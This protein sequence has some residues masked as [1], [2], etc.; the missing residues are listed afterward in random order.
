MM[1]VIRTVT[2]RPS[3]A[4]TRCQQRAFQCRKVFPFRLLLM[5]SLWWQI[6]WCWCQHQQWWSLYWADLKFHWSGSFPLLTGCQH[7]LKIKKLWKIVLMNTIQDEKG[8][9]NRSS[10]HQ[11]T[12]KGQ[13]I[14]R[15]YHPSYH[16]PTNKGQQHQ[17]KN[18][19]LQIVPPP[20]NRQGPDEN[21]QPEHTLFCCKLRSVAIYALFGDLWAKK[22]LLGSKTVF[23]G[24]EVRYNMVFI[25]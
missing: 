10:N 20:T 24:Q 17:Q 1:M 4:A 13:Q 12:N 18:K 14:T 11:P 2:I 23:L 8:Q 15:Y 7:A 9:D 19:G 22:C 5:F 16:Q 6:W 25:A 21:F 3:S